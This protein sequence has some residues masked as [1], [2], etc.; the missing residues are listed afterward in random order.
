MIDERTARLDLPLPS[1]VNSLE[2]DVLR[3]RGALIGLDRHIDVWSLAGESATYSYNAAG[4]LAGVTEQVRGQPRVSTYSYDAAGN[5][6]QAEIVYLGV[7]R[8]ETYS[9]DAAGNITGQTATEAP[10]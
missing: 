8:T 4:N 6:A 2:D 9:Y 3:V 10:V 7:K 5:I 1:P